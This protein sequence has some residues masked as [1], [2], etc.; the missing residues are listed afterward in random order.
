M[1]SNRQ[2]NPFKS[3]IHKKLDSILPERKIHLRT[4]S[5]ISYFLLT[6]NNQL[7]IVLIVFL[8]IGWIQFTTMNFFQHENVLAEKDNEISNSKNAYRTLLGEV[9]NYQ[10]KS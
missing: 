3:F 10:K 9:S 5:K 7:F 6:Q 2:Q 8:F 4:G 1:Q